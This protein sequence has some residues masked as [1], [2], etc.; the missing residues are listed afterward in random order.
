MPKRRTR[1]GHAV[2]ELSL[3]MPW[4]FFLFVGALDFGFYSYSL[5]AVQNAARVAALKT[6]AV[7]DNYTQAL[8]NPSVVESRVCLEVRDELLKMPN[9]AS[10]P[11][12]CSG[13]PLAVSVQAFQDASGKPALRVS[14]GY[15]T[16]PLIP[17]PGLVRKQLRI[18]RV[19]NV[20][21]YGRA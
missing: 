15:D 21:V 6:G 8:S 11:A 2:I 14:V 19:A 5:I 4:L 16:V 13:F 12:N 9:F 18:T 7:Y 3:M 17:I 10:L 1:S 20:R